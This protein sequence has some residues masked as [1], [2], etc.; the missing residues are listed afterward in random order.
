MISEDPPYLLHQDQI[1]RPEAGVQHREEEFHQDAFDVLLNMQKRHFW[2]R[3]RHAFLLA[4]LRKLLG[5][6][7]GLAAIDLGGGCGGW[8]SYLNHREGHRF[9]ELALADSS[10]RALEMA[11]SVVSSSNSRYQIDLRSLGWRERWDTVFLLDVLE[12]IP[13]DELVLRQ[14]WQVL[15]PGGMAFITTPALKRFWGKNDEIVGHH[16]RYS[17][18][19]F[20]RFAVNCGYQETMT[21]YFMFFLSPLYLISRMLEGKKAGQMSESEVAAYLSRT[22]AIPRSPLN[23]ILSAVFWAESLVGLDWSFPWGTSVLCVIR[24]PTPDD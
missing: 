16:T 18:A 13:D 24:K 12:H 23:E 7:T 5:N 14:I 15:K 17:A 6:S 4:A 21:R 19:D 9:S 2:Y 1:W 8:V 20:R 10:Q 11:G 22:H 3:G